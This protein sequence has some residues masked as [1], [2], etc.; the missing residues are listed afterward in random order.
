MRALFIAAPLF[1]LLFASPKIYSLLKGNQTNENTMPEPVWAIPLTMAPKTELP[2][3]EQKKHE[4]PKAEP[5]KEKIKMLKL[6]VNPVVVKTPVEIE[7]PTLDQ[8]DKAVIGP[9]I[10]AGK[11]TTL[12]SGPGEGDG[13]GSGIGVAAGNGTENDGILEMG[14]NIEVYPEFEGG[15]KGWAKYLQRNLRYPYEAEQIKI[16]GKVFVSFVVEKDGSVSN[17]ALV[18]GIHSSINEEAMRVIMKSPRWRPGI[19]NGMKVRV[20][21]TMPISFNIKD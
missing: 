2:K 6:P 8:L 3:P 9:V 11:E 18:K 14:E 17:V 7:P 15:Q 19:Q 20:R 13:K 5:I 10:Q 21:Y 16:Q 12:S 4:L 1:I